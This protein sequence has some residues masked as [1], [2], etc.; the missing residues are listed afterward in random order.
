MYTFT[1]DQLETAIEVLEQLKRAGW[2]EY[3]PLEEVLNELEDFNENFELNIL[4]V[5]RYHEGC[6]MSYGKTVEERKEAEL[7]CQELDKKIEAL[8]LGK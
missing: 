5:E 7:K 3:D 4:K 8:E 2:I 1:K 6:N